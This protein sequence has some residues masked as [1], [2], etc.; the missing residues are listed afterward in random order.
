MAIA[1]PTDLFDDILDFLVS[2]P[3]P[4]AII[5]YKPPAHL[6]QRL[7]D[8]MEKHSRDEVSPDERAEL[9]EFLRMSHLLNR[10]K[11]RARKK[12]SEA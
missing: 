10:L 3:S 12:L 6:D 8:L 9:D 5:A 2:G 11:V 7:Q 4:Q 1:Y